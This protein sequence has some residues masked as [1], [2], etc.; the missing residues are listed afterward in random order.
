MLISAPHVRTY[1]T[2]SLALRIQL[3]P[4]NEQQTSKLELTKSTISHLSTDIYLDAKMT[5]TPAP[6]N[7]GPPPLGHPGPFT[8]QQAA[9]DNAL[10]QAAPAP[11]PAP[12]QT[13]RWRAAL[14]NALNQAAPGLVQTPAV[15]PAPLPPAAPPQAPAAPPQAPAFFTMDQVAL[16]IQGLQA[17]RAST[18]PIPLRPRVGGVDPCGPWTGMG[19]SLKGKRPK[20]S[21]CFR[22]FSSVDLIKSHALLATVEKTCTAGIIDENMH[23]GLAD[24]PTGGKVGYCLREFETGLLHCGMEPVFRIIQEDGPDINMLKEPGK[25]TQLIVEIWVEDLTDRGVWDPINRARLPVCPYDEQNLIWSGDAFEASC[26]PSA[27]QSLHFEIKDSEINGPLALFVY[28]FRAQRPSRARVDAWLTLS[29]PSSS[30]PF[31]EK[32][33]LASS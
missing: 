2:S 8:P 25:L 6:T 12:A 7:P 24:E 23:F 9:F 14:A 20:S 21:D 30:L 16:L 17:Q 33:S 15:V 4:T 19:A 26:T 32:M 27:K 5:T 10:N 22:G 29:R 13:P 11:A 28:L 3:N 31:Q 18:V 1:V